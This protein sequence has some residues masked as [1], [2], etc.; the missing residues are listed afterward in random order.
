[1]S[2]KLVHSKLT[3]GQLA[4]F[5]FLWTSDYD[6]TQPYSGTIRDLTKFDAGFFGVPPKLADVMDPQLR[7]LMEITCETFVDA[8]KNFILTLIISSPEP[9]PKNNTEM[10]M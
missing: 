8:G 6:T 10:E 4:I 1:M 9:E 3:G 7:I 2:Y 5:S